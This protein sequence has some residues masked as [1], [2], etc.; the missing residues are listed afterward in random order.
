[1]NDQGI[2]DEVL[3][4]I[5]QRYRSL[6][7]PDFSFVEAALAWHPYETVMSIFHQRFQVE[8]DTDPNDDV[9]FGYLLT[10]GQQRWILRISMLGPY[11]VLLRL[12]ESDN[13]AVIHATTTELSALE[14]ELTATLTDH[15]IHLL[16]LEV[17]LHPVPIRLFNTERENTRVYQALFSDCDVLPWEESP[18]QA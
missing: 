14:K 15:G 1:M 7:S 2:L 4:L 3:K 6:E 11:A 17:L 16:G 13:A 9:S 10:K 8:E 5:R 18:E 12:D